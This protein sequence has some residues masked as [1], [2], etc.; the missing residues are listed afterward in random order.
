MM[1]ECLADWKDSR[2][3]A[4]LVDATVGPK[5]NQMVVN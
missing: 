1:V 2:S 5:E 3:V 4:H